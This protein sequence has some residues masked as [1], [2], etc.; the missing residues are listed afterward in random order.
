MQCKTISIG[1]AMALAC[2]LLAACASQPALTP[3]STHVV[4]SANGL[5]APE[6]MNATSAYEGIAE[7]RLGPLD[8]LTI[9]VFGIT[10][11]NQDVRVNSG[12][13][14]SLPLIGTVRA[15]GKTIVELQHDI[16]AKLSDGYLQSP[17]VSVFVKEYTSQ[18]VTVEGAVV[19][20]G[21]IP[22][23]G[24]TTLLQVVATSGG[25]TE[26]ADQRGV[27]V[28]RVIKGQK[29][30]AVFNID[31]IGHGAAEDPQIYGD[32]LVV[33]DV[34]GSKSKM[35]TFLQ[36]VPVLGVFRVFGL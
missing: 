31:A 15:G 34:S 16:A 33:V 2:L 22:L 10:E 23:T 19:R 20:P 26:L 32:D 35:R 1:F 29:M 11:L 30:A 24:R 4:I 9:S 17:Q 5:P 6:I 18:R 25:L 36:A 7:Y 8:L 21:V 14:I 28:F 13:E 3:G 12:G 27:V